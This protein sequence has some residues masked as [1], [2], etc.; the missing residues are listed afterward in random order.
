M[1]DYKKRKIDKTSQRDFCGI[2]RS[3]DYMIN[4]MGRRQRIL[5]VLKQICVL[6]CCTTVEVALE[7]MSLKV[8]ISV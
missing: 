3:L 1:K 6:E 8:E 2:P 5:R 7:E 4:A